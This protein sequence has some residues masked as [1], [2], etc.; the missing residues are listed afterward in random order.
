MSQS[1][2]V[3]FQ[4]ITKEEGL[5]QYKDMVSGRS[6]ENLCTQ[7][8][9]R[10]KMFDFAHLYNGQETISMPRGRAGQGYQGGLFGKATSCCCGQDKRRGW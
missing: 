5:V 1:F 8:Y 3:F 6:L 9:Y 2:F 7:M 4:V 10:G